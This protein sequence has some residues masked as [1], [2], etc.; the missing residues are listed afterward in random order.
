MAKQTLELVRPGE[1]Y[2]VEESDLEE[3]QQQDLAAERQ[4]NV[5]EFFRMYEDLY[6]TIPVTGSSNSHQYLV[7]KSSVLV[8]LDNPTQN[9][10]P[11][12]D[13]ITS[14]KNQVIESQQTIVDLRVQ[15]AEAQSK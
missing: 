3:Q 1:W 10:Q 12:L 15:L 13:E 6:Y 5:D 4:E 14:L 7:E 9:L 8:G 11:L 2:R